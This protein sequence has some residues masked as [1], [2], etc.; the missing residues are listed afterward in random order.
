MA[1]AIS[2]EQAEELLKDILEWQ[3]GDGGKVIAKTYKHEDFQNAVV[4]VNQVAKIAEEANH[5]PDIFIHNYNNVT[6][7]L[8]THSA[9]GLSESDFLVAAKIDDL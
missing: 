2:K 9:G 5:H 1:D 3:V 8:T 4:F 6:I 7:S